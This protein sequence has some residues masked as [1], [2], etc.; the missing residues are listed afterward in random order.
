MVA[1]VLIEVAMQAAGDR[2]AL[3]VTLIQDRAVV[4]GVA[5][6]ALKPA[7]ALSLR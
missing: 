7:Q 1:R 2:D 4:V 6:L 5:V 3:Q